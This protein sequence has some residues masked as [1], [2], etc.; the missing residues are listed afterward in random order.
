MWPWRVK[1]PT[2]NL[3]MLLLLLM[4]VMRI[5]LA[6]VCCRF[7]SWDLVI[8]LNFCSDFEHKVWSRIWSWTSSEILK[9]KFGQYFAAERL[10][11]VMKLMFDQDLEV[12]VCLKCWDFEHGNLIKIC[13]W[14]C[15]FGKQNSTLGSVVPL[16]MFFYLRL[17]CLGKRFI[18]SSPVITFDLL[19]LL[20]YYFDFCPYF[21]SIFYC[22]FWGVWGEVHYSWSHNCFWGRSHLA[23]VSS[24]EN[25]RSKILRLTL[26]SF[27]FY[28]RQ[29]F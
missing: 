2:Q 4:L 23:L 8:K 22:S 10:G 1:M 20:S 7:G 28:H 12:K 13:V 17:M 16:A 19:L 11:E 5:V 21:C 25:L 18:T 24:H 6:T 26:M 9:L 3:L 15:Y 14:T 29:V 27:F